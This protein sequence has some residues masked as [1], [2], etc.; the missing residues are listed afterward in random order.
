V[1]SFKEFAESAVMTK[2]KTTYIKK[3]VTVRTNWIFPKI[4][5]IF[6]KIK[7]TEFIWWISTQAV[8]YSIVIS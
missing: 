1:L 6:T 2:T 7:R 5:A 8:T 4:Y 3:T